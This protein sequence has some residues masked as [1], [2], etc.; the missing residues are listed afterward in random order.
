MR[1]GFSTLGC[2]NYDVDQ[3][4]DIAVSNGY[5]GVEIRFLSGT[6][7]LASLPELA[8]GAIAATRRRFED[9]GIAI[10]GIGTSLRMVSLDLDVRA[11]QMD[12]ARR[13]VEIAAGLGAK[14][15]RVFGGPLPP[16]Q[17]AEPTLDAIATGLG[18]IGDLSAQSGVTS[19]LETHDDFCR[20]RSVLDLYRRGMSESVEVL[21]DTLHT[22]RHGENAEETWSLLRDRIR[23]VHVKDAHTANA[24]TF[25][26]ALTG[27]GKV[28][29]RSFLDLLE[30]QGY[31][32]F[33]DFEWEKAWHP[34]IEDPEVAIPH[35][36]R[37]VSGR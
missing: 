10:V 16:A 21:W 4:I 11:Q 8:P 3:V 2:P 1:F 9:A 6:A 7:D 5:A 17:D 36:I 35:F 32:G 28:P 31:A 23:L 34:E 27:E 18:A 30:T 14:F 37:F 26:F 22:W 29:I 33:V 20:S 12:A 24:N 25:D 19:L 15:I 13:N